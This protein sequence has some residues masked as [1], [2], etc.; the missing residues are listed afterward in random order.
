[1]NVRAAPFLAAPF[2]AAPFL[3]APFLRAPFRPLVRPSTYRTL[4][5]LATALPIGAC[6]LAVLIAGFT[7]TAVLAVTPLLVVVLVAFRGAVGLVASADAAL[8]RG[9]LGADVR[10]RI[11]SGGSGYWRRAR[12]VATDPN[13]WRQQ[14]YLV[15]RMTLGF[16]AAVA[17]L[18][19]L[20]ASLGSLVYP[21]WY[22]WGDLH[23]W[24][25]NVDTFGRSWV[26]APA[27]LAGLLVA[28]QLARGL[29]AASAW[30]AVSLLGR[31]GEDARLTP[32]ARRR[33]LLT[34]ATAALAVSALLV[35]IW[36]LTGAGTFWPGWAIAPLV[37]L[38][39]LHTWADRKAG[40]AFALHAGFVTELVAFFIVL[41]ALAGRGYFW[42]EWPLLAGVVTLVVH[43]AVRRG[44]LARRV[45]VLETTRAGAVDAEDAK[46]RRI[47][48][49]L[50]DGAQARLVALG[51]NLGLAE[52]TLESDPAAAHELVTEARQG[53]QEALT[54]LRD[55]VR[56]IHPPVLADRGLA[57]ALGTLADRSAVPV[58]VQ[59]DL[60]H[61]P[62]VP[63]ESALYFVAAE[64][65]ANA[66][67][68]A[69]ASQIA[70]RIRRN[71]RN[72]EAEI[73]DD[74][75]GGADDAGGGLVGLRRR[76]E[77][78]DGRLVVLSPPGGPTIVRA[79]LPCES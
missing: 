75:Q 39:G 32:G 66:S 18:S 57:A 20:A 70:V 61:R 3:A 4:L 31:A 56:G 48:R 71:G 50:H 2:L 8:V 73:E 37:L 28:L 12:L 41:W 53:V 44:T 15:V 5:Y 54:E 16:A 11:T 72:I 63:L 77:A 40:D 7:A 30:L 55:L 17:E 58:S 13:F 42:P 10:P 62:V 35:L 59:V 45:E 51:I 38:V 69:A 34:H 67:K 60:D 23:F 25:W 43:L 29:G 6:T 68:H 26:V 47:E 24:S 33:A 74:G 78:L 1:M 64:A 19:L 14:A 52:R 65:L 49:D 27:G 21:A 9:L 79:E 76:V 46:L 36:A 22:R